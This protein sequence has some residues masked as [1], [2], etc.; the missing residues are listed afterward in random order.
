[1]IKGLSERQREKDKKT[2]NY[3]PWCIAVF[4]R[5]QFH[6]DARHMQWS[7]NNDLSCTARQDGSTRRYKNNTR[8]DKY[9]MK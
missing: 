1:M 9:Y 5:S 3:R 4:I 8:L 2:E 6:G 7:A